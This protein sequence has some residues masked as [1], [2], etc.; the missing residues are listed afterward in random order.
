MKEAFLGS[1][2]EA[3]N[4][5]VSQVNSFVKL[6]RLLTYV[7]TYV[8]MGITIQLLSLIRSQ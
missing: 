4:V 8:D 6:I 7:N 1:V 2:K 5:G 3:K